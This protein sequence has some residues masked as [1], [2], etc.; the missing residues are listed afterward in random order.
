MQAKIINTSNE[1]S[2]AVYLLSGII[3]WNL[4]YEI[5][6]KLLKIFYTYERLIK[7]FNFPKIILPIIVVTVAII[8]FM[9]TF[10]PVYIAFLL[11][12]HNPNEYLYWLPILICITALYAFSLG[13]LFGVLNVFFKDIEHIVPILLQFLFWLTPI[14]YFI[15][16][17]PKSVSF[18]LEMNPMYLIINSFHNVLTFNS[19]PDQNFIMYL[20]FICSG[21]FILALYVFNKTQRNLTDLL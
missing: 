1:Y 12:G 17:V 2:Y 15:D 7:T 13:L 10:I 18:L 16:F 14:V 8:N 11:L 9:I 19:P 5:I 20:V 6:I 4:F 3:A 21:L